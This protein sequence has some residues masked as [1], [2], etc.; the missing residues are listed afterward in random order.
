MKLLVITQSVDLKD[1]VLGFF[2]GWLEE[3]STQCQNVTV[4]CLRKGA[5]D[6]P[7][8]VEVFSLGK[9]TGNSRLVVLLNFLRFIFLKS[10][11]YDGIFIHM[12]PIYLVFGGLLWKF[13]GKKVFLWYSH[14]NVDW[15]LRVATFFSSKIFSTSKE[16]FGIKSNKVVFVGHG[17]NLSDFKNILPRERFKGEEVV[18]TSV[19]RI[20]RVKNIDVLIDALS[21]INNQVFNLKVNL[22]G[23]VL[24]DDDRSYKKELEEKIAV[25]GLSKKISFCG[26]VK[27]D[28]ILSVYNNSD[29]F[30]NL[31]DDGGMDKVVLESLLCYCP[32]FFKNKS[33]LNIYG[34]L[35]KQFHFENFEDL[36]FKIINFLEDG[37]KKYDGIKLRNVVEKGYNLSGLIKVIVRN[38]EQ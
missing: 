24:S 35:G 26:F 19:S 21:H 33:F 23:D 17:I 15:K 30:I 22:Y 34:D 4:L 14:K 9:E 28:E 7:N 5:F 32:T 25:L 38:Y 12:N 6:L 18:L 16:G 31:S 20:S 37:Y 8:N 27:H 11:N 13:L 2:H 1:P 10:K 3:F 36:S 29:I